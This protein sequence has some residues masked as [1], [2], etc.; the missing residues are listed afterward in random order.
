MSAAPVCLTAYRGN[1]GEGP[2]WDTVSQRLFWI[3]CVD[4]MMYCQGAAGTPLG[5]WTLPKAPGSFALREAGGMIVA[6]RNGIGLIDP[7]TATFEEIAAGDVDFAKERFNDGKC[8]AKGRFWAG[9]MDRAVSK[10]V[11]SLYRIDADRSVHRMDDG[12]TLSNGI[13]WSPDSRT[14][15]YCDSRPGVVRAYDF[16]LKAGAVANRRVFADFASRK[17]M[18]DGC[19]VDAE[20]CVWVVEVEAGQVVRFA[21]D[22]R[23]MGAVTLP[24]SKP[25]SVMFG[26]TDLRTLFVTSMRYGLHAEEPQ[27]GYVF[28]LDVG[29]AGLP[30]HRFAG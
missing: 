9:T 3:D 17:G 26:G 14:M 11:G 7:F 29:V 18:P 25:T 27:A 5:Q 20:G 8:D 22:G 2:V 24:V 1:L 6:Y 4:R 10:P 19:T 13:A 23:E 12:I 30:A 16:D 15:Y 21:P 28:A